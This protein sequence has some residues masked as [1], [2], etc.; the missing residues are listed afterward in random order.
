MEV[1][2]KTIQEDSKE[3]EML[4]LVMRFYDHYSIPS[5]DEAYWDEVIK[6]AHKVIERFD[7]TPLR[8]PV[9]KIMV[10][11]CDALEAKYKAM[12]KEGEK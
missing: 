7:G 9:S 4:S 10:G 12:I 2:L 8:Q 1:K 11:M 6:Y 3:A 5:A